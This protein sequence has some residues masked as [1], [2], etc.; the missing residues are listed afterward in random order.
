M[1][2][3]TAHPVR[4]RREARGLSQVALAAAAQLTRQSIGALEAGRAVPAVDVALRIAAALG[5]TVEELFAMGSTE[6]TL[7]AERSAQGAA[8]QAGSHMEAAR[9]VALGAADAGIGTRDVAIAFGRGFIPLAVERDDLVIPVVSVE[10]PRVQLL[11]TLTGAS[12]R[13]E[14]EPLGYDVRSSGDPVAEVHAA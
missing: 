1:P 6:T 9:L 4:L 13:R 14:L 11:D 3:A 5:C 12:T 8:F 10:D 2:D 7:Q